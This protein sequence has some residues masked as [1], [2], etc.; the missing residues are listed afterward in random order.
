[1]CNVAGCVYVSAGLRALGL[2]IN[3]AELGADE[4]SHVTP[5]FRQWSIHSY[6]LGSVDIHR[7]IL[8]Q[9][10][11]NTRRHPQA[12]AERGFRLRR[13]RAYPTKTTEDDDMIPA[14]TALSVG[15]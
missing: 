7:W 4:A 8:K 13:K 11:S 5:V 15:K 1:M 6:R 9:L 2:Y 10:T 14:V 12:E 3:P